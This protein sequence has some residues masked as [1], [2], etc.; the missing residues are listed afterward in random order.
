MKVPGISDETLNLLAARVKRRQLK[1]PGAREAWFVTGSG[2]EVLINFG[3]DG[4][5]PSWRYGKRPEFVEHIRDF[6]DEVRA[7]MKAKKKEA[8]NA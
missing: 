7:K 5:E 3:T 6:R 2:E 8:K 1:T 4:T